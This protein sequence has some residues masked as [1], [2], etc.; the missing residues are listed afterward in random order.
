MTSPRPSSLSS[1]PRVRIGKQLGDL[2]DASLRFYRQIGVEDASLPGRYLTEVRRSRPLPPPAQEGPGGAHLRAFDFDRVKDLPV[3]PSVGSHTRDQMW[4]RLEYFLKAVVPAA[5]DAG[6]KLAMYPN[7]PPVEVFRGVAQPV[8][9]L[10]DLQDQLAIVDSPANCLFL[11]TGVLT[12]MGEDAPAAVRR[13]GARGRI[14]A[15]HF[16][17]V[18]VRTPYTRYV[19]TFH[20]EGDCDMAAC[21]RA[22]LETGY[23]GALDPDHSPGIDDD[24]A[25]TH[26]GWA[27]AIGQLIGLRA[28][29]RGTERR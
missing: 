17:N 16:R 11:D 8:P 2:T 5:E 1:L 26:K 15:I 14:A 21:M 7:D 18:R 3:I 24:T 22:F 27:F 9:S 25:D 20:D 13:F 10:A 12:E 23:D 4:E 19:E 28:A 29:A 6:V